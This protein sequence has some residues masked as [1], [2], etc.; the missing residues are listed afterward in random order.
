M[1]I[2]FKKCRVASIFFRSEPVI[3][4]TG[5]SY[6]FQ[7]LHSGLLRILLLSS[8]NTHTPCDTAVTK[9]TTCLKYGSSHGTWDDWKES[10]KLDCHKEETGSTYKSVY[11]RMSWDEP[12][13]TITTQFF[14][15]GTG[16]FGHPEQNRALTI[17]E[18]AILQ[19]FPNDYIFVGDD[20]KISMNNLGMHIGNAVPPR[21]GEIIG[22]SIITHIEQSILGDGEELWRMTI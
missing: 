2:I 8:A 15:Y 1:Y 21:L 11:G 9:E 4:A 14:N 12:S 13:P 16:R 17:R 19:T 20:E 18:A 7:R 3:K 22:E 10:L 5:S 6:S